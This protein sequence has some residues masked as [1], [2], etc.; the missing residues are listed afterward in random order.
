MRFFTAKISFIFLFF[1]AFGSHSYP[2]DLR[3]AGRSPFVSKAVADILQFNIDSS[4]V[5]SNIKINSDGIKNFY[6]AHKFKRIALSAVAF[7]SEMDHEELGKVFNKLDKDGDG[8]LSYKELSEG[9]NTILGSKAAELLKIYENNLSSGQT[10]N[11]HGK[12]P[13]LLS[14]PLTP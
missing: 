7:Y 12:G 6:Q 4:P 9:L 1:V 14:C 11:Y 8:H 13:P 3:T 5:P 2:N 10:I